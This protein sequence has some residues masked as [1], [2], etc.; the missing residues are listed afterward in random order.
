[1]LDASQ[2]GCINHPGMAAT[3]R[4]KQCS[5][6]M[7]DSCAV[8]GPTGVFCSAECKQRHESYMQ[9][10]QEMDGRARGTFFTKLKGA[11]TWLIVASVACLSMAFVSTKINIPIL[12]GIVQQLRNKFGI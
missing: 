1:M 11:I 10:A 9:R 6:P 3:H 12:S 2:S 4:C 7:C 8:R 5:T